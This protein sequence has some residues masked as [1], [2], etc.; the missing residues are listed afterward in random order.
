MLEEAVLSLKAGSSAPVADR[1]SQQITIGTAL[2]ITEDYV[3]DM[4]V[5][6][7]LYRLLA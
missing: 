5:R 2:L 4:S 1:W 3:A 7:A 6:L